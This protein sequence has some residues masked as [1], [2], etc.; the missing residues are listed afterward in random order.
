MSMRRLNDAYVYMLSLIADGVEYPDAQWRASC[1]F[2]VHHTQ[3]QEMYDAE[4]F[5]HAQAHRKQ[6]DKWPYA[7]LTAK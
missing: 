2:D 6:E 4:Q 1:D 3:L 5:D 7:A